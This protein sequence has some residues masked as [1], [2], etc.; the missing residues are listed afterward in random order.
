MYSSTANQVKGGERVRDHDPLLD[1]I[2]LVRSE[3]QIYTFVFEE[4]QC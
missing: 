4:K 2:V 3:T 1:K